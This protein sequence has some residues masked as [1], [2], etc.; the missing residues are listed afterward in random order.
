MPLGVK[1]LIV[2]LALVAVTTVLITPDPTD[3]VQGIVHHGNQ[4]P[5]LAVLV[6]AWLLC[7]VALR[8]RFLLTRD[9]VRYAAP[10]L[11]VICTRL[12]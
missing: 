11:D 10:S 7:L 5:K 2:A 12:C 9:S 4:L 8:D 1:I 3:D 6:A